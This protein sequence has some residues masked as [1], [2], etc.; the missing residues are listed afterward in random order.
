MTMR[1]FVFDYECHFDRASKYTL[2][3]MN[4]AEYILDGRFEVTG[5]AVKELGC[6]AQ[7]IE[8]PDIGAFLGCLDPDDTTTISHHALFDAPISSYRYGFVPKL[9]VCTLGIARAALNLK[10]YSL[11]SVA[12]HLGLPAKGEE[13]HQADGMRLV[14]LKANPDFYCKYIDYALND[15][16]LCE[17]IFD[18]LVRTG[19][20]PPEEIRVQDLVLRCAVQ[21]VLHANVPMLKEHLADLRE[22]KQQLLD[23]CGHDRATL[24]STAKFKGALE[25]HGVA[26]KTKISTTGRTTAAIAKTDPFMADLAEH[27]DA[28]VRALA[29]A[30]LAFKSTQEETRC[31]RFLDIAALP[32]PNGQP[33]LPIPLIYAGAKTHRLAGTWEMNLQNLARDTSKSKLRSSI[34]APEGFKIVSAD[35]SQVEAR[36]AA[37][38]CGQ[39]DLL[40]A[41]RRG[42]DVYAEFASMVFGRPITKKNNPVERFIG[43]TGILSLQYGSGW[44]RFHLM[45]TTQARAAGIN[46]HGVFDEQVAQR[47]V[48]MYRELY[49]RIPGFWRELDRIKQFILLNNHTSQEIGLGPVTIM[50]RRIRLPNGLCL[51]YDDPVDEKLWGGTLLNHICQ[52]L[53]YVILMQAA[54]RLHRK[55]LRFVT[56]IHDELA[57][58]VRDEHVEQAKVIIHAEMIRPPAWMP[59]LPLAVEIGVGDDYGGV[60]AS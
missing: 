54:R 26:V 55:G 59:E 28:G 12:E 38:I 34:I 25:D 47:T 56:Q 24:M 15:D 33:M 30:R 13:I 19:I 5:L 6:P 39:T 44:L 29:K 2:E 50:S 31:E 7:W 16:T 60:K 57:F 20:F 40:D 27:Q 21:P 4:P 1:A 10:S 41:F 51:R 9:I 3:H 43:K 49:D 48:R 42:I 46:L 52:S 36:I 37:C 8:G 35:S 17:G 53:A 18:K 14:D 32:W 11:K 23:A 45:V 58:C 22:H